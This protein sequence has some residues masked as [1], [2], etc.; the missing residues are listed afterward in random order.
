MTVAG[1]TAVKPPVVELQEK[2]VRVEHA[3]EIIQQAKSKVE[4]DEY[5]N[6]MGEQTYY[7][8]SPQ[9]SGDRVIDSIATSSDAD[10][11]PEP[12]SEVDISDTDLPKVKEGNGIVDLPM[13]KHLFG[14]RTDRTGWLG[15]K[16]EFFEPS[17]KR[18]LVD[19]VMREFLLEKLIDK[20]D[21]WTSF[22][23]LSI[24]MARP[25]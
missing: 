14:V 8:W 19:Q 25:D 22:L 13:K 9:D 1:P 4:D 17:E 21:T 3:T 6:Q 15:S 11:E 12:G 10:M 23:D 20:P 18:L 5:K 7:G 16:S 2:A 24:A